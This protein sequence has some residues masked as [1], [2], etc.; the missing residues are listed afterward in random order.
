M[1]FSLQLLDDSLVAYYSSTGLVY[2]DI[3]YN[4]QTIHGFG[5]MECEAK[6]VSS[7]QRRYFLGE[8]GLNSENIFGFKNQGNASPIEGDKGSEMT[9]KWQSSS[10]QF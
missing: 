6:I 10:V 5:A 2:A 7:P 4:Q 1:L 8:K 9:M 3:L